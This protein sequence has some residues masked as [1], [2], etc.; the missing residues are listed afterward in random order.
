MA[1]SKTR[2]DHRTKRRVKLAEHPL[3]AIEPTDSSKVGPG[4]IP[5]KGQ[6]ASETPAWLFDLLDHEVEEI[7]GHRFELDAAASSPRAIAP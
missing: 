2:L 7:V 4:V 1:A 6:D 5:G 3:P